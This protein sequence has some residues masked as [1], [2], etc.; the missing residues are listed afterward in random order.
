MAPV[1]GAPELTGWWVR[2]GAGGP[3]TFLRGGHGVFVAALA[4]RAW[5]RR[6]VGTC[7]V[8]V[9]VN[10][11]RVGDA[12]QSGGQTRALGSSDVS[13]QLGVGTVEAVDHDRC[14]P[15]E[16][17]AGT[18]RAGQCVIA[19]YCGRPHGSLRVEGDCYESWCGVTLLDPG[20]S[21]A[22]ASSGGRSRAK[23]SP[24]SNS[25]SNPSHALGWVVSSHEPT[26]SRATHQFAEEE[27]AWVLSTNGSDDHLLLL[28]PQLLSR[29]RPGVVKL[30]VAFESDWEP[31]A[32]CTSAPIVDMPSRLVVA[33][34]GAVKLPAIV[35][36]IVAQS[37]KSDRGRGSGHLSA[38]V[39]FVTAGGH[40]ASRG[41]RSELTRAFAGRLHGELLSSA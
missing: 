16:H 20:P 23:Y 39:D 8:A 14:V 34:L 31:W 12:V 15:W 18:G 11:R 38:V 41:C 40:S 17:A 37:G 27:C 19:A 21:L 24:S 26:Y 13:C 3:G 10:V 9:P 29:I 25:V 6:T 7:S 28:E 22:T 2:A 30:T 36:S 32:R 33:C 1:K 5:P 35:I 4:R